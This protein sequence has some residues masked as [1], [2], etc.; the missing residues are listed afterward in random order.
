VD[1][2][3][4]LTRQNLGDVEQTMP[5]YFCRVHKS[6]IVNLARVAV[7]ERDKITIGE[8]KIPLADSYRDTFMKMSKIR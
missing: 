4:V 6:F 1:G 5:V 8:R 2:R 3:K 7:I